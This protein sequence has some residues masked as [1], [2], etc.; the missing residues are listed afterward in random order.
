MTGARGQDDG[1]ERAEL[2]QSIVTLDHARCC[3][4]DR[5]GCRAGLRMRP[6][7]AAFFWY[8]DLVSDPGG[9][10]VSAASSPGHPAQQSLVGSADRVARRR[11]GV[12][13][14]G[15]RGDVA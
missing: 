1:L 8:L 15:H 4:S 3:A 9:D 13:A 10:A 2:W 12:G 5:A 11:L 7:P 14:D 6:D